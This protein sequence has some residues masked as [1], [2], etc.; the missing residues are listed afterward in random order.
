MRLFFSIEVANTLKRLSKVCLIL[1]ETVKSAELANRALQ[2]YKET[3]GD[4][5][6]H[7]EVGQKTLH[8]RCVKVSTV[9]FLFCLEGALLTKNKS[10][11][12]EN[13][14]HV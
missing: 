12:I 3:H 14:V 7:R 8:S 10:K 11:E 5:V 9:N 1:G 4:T 6:E 2:I 13:V